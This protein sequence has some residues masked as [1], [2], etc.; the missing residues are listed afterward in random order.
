MKHL[1]QTPFTQNTNSAEDDVNWTH[2]AEI[3]VTNLSI[4]HAENL[5]G[6]GTTWK[7]EVSVLLQFILCCINVCTKTTIYLM[8]VRW[9]SGMNQS[10]LNV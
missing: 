6:Y 9:R 3:C 10:N 4:E 5:T 8:A 1:W 2:S 7:F